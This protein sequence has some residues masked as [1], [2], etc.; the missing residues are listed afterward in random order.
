M[1]EAQREDGGWG[2]GGSTPA[3]VEETSL[4]VEALVSANRYFLSLVQMPPGPGSL[5]VAGTFA[6]IENAIARGVEWLIHQTD[7]GTR[8]DPTPIGFYF[9][10]LWYYEKLYP[11][12]FTVAALS[13]VKAYAAR[14]I[15]MTK[16]E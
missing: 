9:A 15:R 13:S 6:Q 7:H 11:L 3:S 12:I 8:F 1:V 10:K 16:H 5:N 2:V 4:A 14:Q